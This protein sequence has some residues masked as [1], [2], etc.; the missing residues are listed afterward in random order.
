MFVDFYQ[1]RVVEQSVCVDDGL[2]VGQLAEL[3]CINRG[4][5]YFSHFLSVVAI[6]TSSIFCPDFGVKLIVERWFGGIFF[7]CCIYLYLS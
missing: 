5:S 6:S 2:V 7:C 3:V 4:G 1:A